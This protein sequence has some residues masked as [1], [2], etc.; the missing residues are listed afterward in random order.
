MKR[1]ITTLSLITVLGMFS[2]VLGA[3]VGKIKSLYT[4]AESTAPWSGHAGIIQIQI[5]GGFDASGDPS[6]AAV[7]QEDKALVATLLSA[8]TNGDTISVN[9][10]K[11]PGNTVEYYY[12]SRRRITGISIQKP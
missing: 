12:D 11:H 6:Y 9:F 5:E 4:F 7:Y 3:N 8:W 1:L 10:L 2:K